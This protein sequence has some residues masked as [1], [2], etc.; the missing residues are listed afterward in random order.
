M[1]EYPA[2]ALSLEHEKKVLKSIEANKVE[3]IGN[4][5][6]GKVFAALY[7]FKTLEYGSEDVYYSLNITEGQADVG[8]QSL[9]YDYQPVGVLAEAVAPTLGEA[10]TLLKNYATDQGFDYI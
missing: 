2:W 10:M 6:T 7:V 4:R 8:S 1:T 3:K 5:S 9:R